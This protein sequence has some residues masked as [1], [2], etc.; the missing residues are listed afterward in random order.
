MSLW[1][2]IRLQNGNEEILLTASQKNPFRIQT[3]LKLE[4]SLYA[5]VAEVFLKDFKSM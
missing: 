2:H 5:S 1:W 3:G 4:N